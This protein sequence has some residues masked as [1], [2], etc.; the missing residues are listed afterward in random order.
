[1]RASVKPVSAS[2]KTIEPLGSLRCCDQGP[3][4]AC[5]TPRCYTLGAPP[6]ARE[7]KSCGRPAPPRHLRL[8]EPACLPTAFGGALVRS[9]SQLL[10][11]HLCA[12]PHSF[13]GC[14]CA[15]LPTAFGGALVRSSSSCTPSSPSTTCS[16]ASPAARACAAPHPPPLA[17]PAP[18][19]GR[20]PRSGHRPRLSCVLQRTWKAC[21]IA[22]NPCSAPL[23]R[24]CS[25]NVHGQ[26]RV[27]CWEPCT[28]HNLV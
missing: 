1:V 26:A 5:A 7:G 27:Q 8:K 16:H 6:M 19:T 28:Q 12:A 9:S 4:D 11:V 2:S 20:S 17:C 22:C 25:L 10:G 18:W 15:Q 13:W 3:A 14:T 23:L 24:S 21:A